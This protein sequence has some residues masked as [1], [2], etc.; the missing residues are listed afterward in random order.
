VTVAI[1]IYPAT[2]IASALVVIA[3]ELLVFR[4][5]VFRQSAF[6]MTMLIVYAFMIPVDGWLTAMPEPI[7][8][9]RPSD[10]SGW[11]PIWDILAE[12]Y[13]YA[14]G[15]LTLTIVLWERAGR[16]TDSGARNER[17][18]PAAEHERSDV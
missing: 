2:A 8:G 4:T 18:H 11:R 6:W 13:V 1:A 3:L 10:V 15:L 16:H 12:E 17:E 14:F 7:V 5:G 9:Y